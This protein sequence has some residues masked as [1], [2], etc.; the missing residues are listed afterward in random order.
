VIVDALV[1][2]LDAR[3]EV[4]DAPLGVSVAITRTRKPA[5]PAAA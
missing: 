2:Q 3:L 4:L 5:L 1:K